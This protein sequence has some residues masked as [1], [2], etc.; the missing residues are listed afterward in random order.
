MHGTVGARVRFLRGSRDRSPTAVNVQIMRSKHCPSRSIRG[1]A[2]VWTLQDPSKLHSGKPRGR[3][4]ELNPRLGGMFAK[5]AF[6][7]IP[8]RM[9]YQPTVPSSNTGNQSPFAKIETDAWVMKS[10]GAARAGR[11]S[12]L[13]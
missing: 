5:P 10:D 1:Q 8:R 6:V 11:I 9:H 13:S 3:R 2:W 4:R 7:F 12:W